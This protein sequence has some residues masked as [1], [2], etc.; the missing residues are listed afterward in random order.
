MP[1]ARDWLAPGEQ[2]QP[3]YRAIQ[4][5]GQVLPVLEEDGLVLFESGAILL[6]LGERSETLLLPRDPAARARA[7]Q[8]VFAALNSV[9]PSLQ[10]PRGHRRVLQGRGLGKAA[11]FGVRSSSRAGGWRDFRARWATSPISMA[12][13]SLRAT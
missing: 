1:I 5:F 9:E 7:T 6:H 3:A 8:W 2:D 11:A 4:P 13:G 12:S 10:S